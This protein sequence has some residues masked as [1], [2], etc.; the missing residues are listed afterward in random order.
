MPRP[1][2]RPFFPRALKSAVGRRNVSWQNRVN[3]WKNDTGIPNLAGRHQVSFV[4][5]GAPTDGPE[6]G[7]GFAAKIGSPVAET[8]S[9]R[10]LRTGSQI[11]ET[12]SCAQGKLLHQ[13]SK[14]SSCT[15]RQA[16]APQGKGSAGLETA[17]GRRGDGPETHSRMAWWL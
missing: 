3:C 6:E 16:L 9:Q 4:Q 1:R 13:H 14:A 11:G 8:E 12:G 17:C 2:V 5:D 15:S 7:L 10:C